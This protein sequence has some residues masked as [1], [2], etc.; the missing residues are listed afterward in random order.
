MI[1][2]IILVFALGIGGIGVYFLTNIYLASIEQEAAQKVREENDLRSVLAFGRDLQRGTKL[3]E[4]DLVWQERKK[5]SIPASAYVR[6]TMPNAVQNLANTF[7]ARGVSA[8]ELVLPELILSSGAGFMALAIRPGMR[9][10][11]VRTSAVQ[12]AG[13]FVQPEDRI[14]VIHTVVRDLDG[15]G[16][17]N[18]ISETILQNVRVLA[19]GAIPTDRTI[20]KTSAEQQQAKGVTG[21]KV[22]QAETITLELTDEQ[23]RLL[24]SAGTNGAITFALRPVGNPTLL[25]ETGSLKTM[26][27]ENDARTVIVEP[28][29]GTVPSPPIVEQRVAPKPAE[30]KVYVI[31]PSG[32]S[33]VIFQGEDPK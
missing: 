27:N 24:I 8:G 6:E 14:D 26:T 15:D 9:A 17:A 21:D 13:G 18:G 5:D 28:A 19:V 23:A 1:F 7:I 4:Q 29:Q 16:V 12:I 30:R 10:I 25:P 2:R 20:A 22:V 33:T 31:S 11:A 32:Q 3:S